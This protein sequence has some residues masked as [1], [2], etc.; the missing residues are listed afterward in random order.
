MY[1][2]FLIHSLV[3][4]IHFHW[5]KTPWHESCPGVWLMHFCK[6]FSSSIKIR[7][8]TEMGKGWPS[9]CLYFGTWRYNYKHTLQRLVGRE[10]ILSKTQNRVIGEAASIQENRKGLPPEIVQLTRKLGKVLEG[11]FPKA[12]GGTMKLALPSFL[13]F[14]LRYLLSPI[15]LS[16]FKSGHLFSLS[17]H[18]QRQSISELR[19]T[20]FCDA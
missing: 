20:H 2:I 15:T 11:V 5:P 19:R 18:W 12:G 13:P 1:H 3:K 14:V 16:W 7:S 17:S 4:K 10:M 9:C 6:T 8:G